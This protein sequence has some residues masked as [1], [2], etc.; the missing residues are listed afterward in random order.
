MDRDAGG[1]KALLI[2]VLSFCQGWEGEFLVR[3]QSFSY[4]PSM[5]TS[6]PSVLAAPFDIQAAFTNPPPALDF[7]MPGFVAGTV[8]ALVA[9]GATSKSFFALEAG[10]EIACSAV[11]EILLGLCPAQHG[12]VVYLAGEDPHPVLHSRIYAM[13]ECLPLAARADIA[14]NFILHPTMGSMFNIGNKAHL[15]ALIKKSYGVRLLVLDTLSRIYTGDENSNGEMAK[16]V[17]TL[18]H[19]AVQTGAAVLF[20]HHVSKGSAKDGAGNTQQAARGASSLIDN[21]RWCS[22]LCSMTEEQGE[23]FMVVGDMYPIGDRYKYFV[24]FGVSKV[25]YCAP[26]EAIWFERKDGGVLRPVKLTRY[27]ANNSGGGY[28]HVD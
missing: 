25:N 27:S 1:G 16:V 17:S 13:G 7:V 11:K 6:K 9:P 18:E 24:S 8:G 5:Q 4:P 23:D 19:V 28:N 3:K 10:M 14:A 20:L 26:V 2:H 15:E 21:A 22:Y 12:K